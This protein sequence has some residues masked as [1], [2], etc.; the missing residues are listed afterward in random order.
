MIRLPLG[1]SVLPPPSPRCAH[2]PGVPRTHPDITLASAS[3]PVGPGPGVPATGPASAGARG[4]TPAGG[5]PGDAERGRLAALVELLD[6]DAPAIAGAAR[7]GL[8]EAGRRARPFLGR[9]E[10]SGRARLR[11]RAR[12]LLFELEREQV[13]R[14][15]AR[16][17]SSAAG[18]DGGE[19]DLERAL[20]LMG[21]LDAPALDARPYLRALDAMGAEVRARALQQPDDFT[22]P[23]VL[24][25]YLGN[26]L[27]YVGSEVDYDHPDHIHLHRAIERKRGMPLT[28]TAIYLFVARRAGLRA[29]AVPLPGHVLLRLYAGERSLLVDPFHGGRIRQRA[30]CLRYL[31]QHGLTPQA[32]WFRDA[33]DASLFQRHLLNLMSS[34]QVR[35]RTR[36][37]RRLHRIARLLGQARRAENTPA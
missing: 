33:S 24:P 2:P 8:A 12:A 19:L 28:L 26:E 18:A 30:D 3:E 22:R 32:S 34:H 31:A 37:A 15:L 14:R 21:R 9:A 36:L 20:F 25:E 27:G 23:M 11:A 17:A 16:R 1:A 6:D 4:G 13:L 5:A 35:G 10:R 29:A 7:E